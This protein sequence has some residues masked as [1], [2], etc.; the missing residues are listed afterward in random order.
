MTGIAAD[1]MSKVFEPFFTTKEVGKGTGLGLSQVYGFAR[2]AGGDVQ[3]ASEP[4]E[5]TTVTLYLPRVAWRLQPV[6]RQRRA[7]DVDD[8][9][10]A[11]ARILVVEDNHRRSA[12]SARCCW[13]N[14]AIA[15]AVPSGPR[16]RW[17]C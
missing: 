9:R 14:S 6:W 5:G 3:V 15:C 11:R 2:Q 13:N 10:T 12:K 8:I 1:M 4:G 17:P 7:V 16:Q